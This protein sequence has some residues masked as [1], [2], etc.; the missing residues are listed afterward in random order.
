MP[1]TSV[2]LLN[3]L[4]GSIGAGYMVYGRRNHHLQATLCGLLLMVVPSLISAPLPLLLA[5]TAL[6]AVPFLLRS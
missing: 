4:L 5:G 6:M 1:S 3:V 2:L